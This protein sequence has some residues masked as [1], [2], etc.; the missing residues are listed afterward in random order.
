[1]SE[2]KVEKKV[3]S[4]TLA[5][6]LGI[7]CIVLAVGL[8]GAVVDYT[9]IINDKNS[10]ISSQANTIS[11][12]ASTISGYQSQVSDLTGK[13]GLSQSTV[14]VN[15]QTVSQPASYYSTWTES[16]SYAGYVS[17]YVQSSSVLGTWVEVSYYSHGLNYSQAYTGSQAINVGNSAIFPLLPCSSITIGVGNGNIFSSATETVTITYY[18]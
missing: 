8:V 2:P 12:Q 3:V 4:R 13:L 1:M 16:A 9:S 10:T 14:W 6:A 7:V 17:V 11:S 15:D 5:I 18:Y